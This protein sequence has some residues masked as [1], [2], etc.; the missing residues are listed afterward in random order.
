MV[1]L[2]TTGLVGKKLFKLSKLLGPGG[3]LLALFKGDFTI[4][5]LNLDIFDEDEPDAAD[6]GEFK[7]P[8]RRPPL[9]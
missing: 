3:F 2:C 1:G 8:Q 4:L 5:A 9:P 6:L 7:R